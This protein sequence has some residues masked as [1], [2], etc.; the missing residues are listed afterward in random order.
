MLEKAAFNAPDGQPYQLVQLANSNGMTVYSSSGE[1]HDSA[2][3]EKG[4]Y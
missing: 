3:D 4:G 1:S 2:Y